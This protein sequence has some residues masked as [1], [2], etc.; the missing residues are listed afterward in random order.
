[1]AADCLD[2]MLQAGA[3]VNLYMFHGGTNFGFMNGANANTPAEYAP[4][5]TSYDYDAPLSECGDITP[6]YLAFREAIAKIRP[7]V[8]DMPLPAPSPKAAYG[9]LQL[10]AKAALFDNLDAIGTRYECADTATMET[11]GQAYGYILYRHRLAARKHRVTLTVQ[12]PRDRAQVIIDG[13]EAAV[14]YRTD[15]HH[16]L[17]L[18][19]SDQESQLDILVENMGRHNYGPVLEDNRK[20]ISFGVRLNLQ[21]QYG[22][23]IYTLPLD[24]LDQLRFGTVDD[25]TGPAFFQAELTVDEPADTFLKVP[26]SKGMVWINGFNLGRY[27]SEGPQRTLYVPGALLRRGVNRVMVFEQHRLLEPLVEFLDVPELG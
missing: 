21:F 19:P 9:K 7:E 13:R 15:A 17:P 2:R 12:E 10:T 16:S 22:W 23:E 14:F 26:G 3:H 8:R 1:D 5:T 27:W 24:N 6:K 4:T 25:L 11:F 20:G 18:P